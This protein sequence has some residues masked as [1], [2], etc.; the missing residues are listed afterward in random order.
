MFPLRLTPL[1]L[2]CALALPAAVQARQVTI[3]TQLKS[4]G[5]GGS[6]LALYLTDARGAYAGTLAVAYHKAKYFKHLRDWN[7]LS[8]GDGQRLA[9]ITG[10]SVGAARTF[11]VSVELADT[12]ID[13]GYEIRVDAAEEDLGDTPSAVRVPLTRAGAGAVHPG[14]GVLVQSLRY[15]L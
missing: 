9:G 8:A 10:A 15:Q 2:A 11:R 4:H 12:L 3:E 1:A 14:R 7:R 5:G 13:A 6:Y